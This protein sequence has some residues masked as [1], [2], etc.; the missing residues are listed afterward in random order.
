[1]LAWRASPG[2]RHMSKRKTSRGTWMDSVSTEVPSELAAMTC[3][4]DGVHGHPAA[5][6]WEGVGF[7]QGVERI[8][9]LVE[10]IR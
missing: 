5:A 9:H 4:M 1:M 6:C 8:D 10:R 7:D 2:D 3:A